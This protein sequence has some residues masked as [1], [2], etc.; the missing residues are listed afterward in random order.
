[1]RRSPGCLARLFEGE[2]VTILASKRLESEHQGRVDCV[3]VDSLVRTLYEQ[4]NNP[5][6]S[7]ECEPAGSCKRGV[8]E[9]RD[10][11]IRHAGGARRLALVAIGSQVVGDVLALSDHRHDSL[12]DGFGRVQLTQMP[13]HHRTAQ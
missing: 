13:E 8:L 2:V 9:T 3:P 12:L 4:R 7:Q 6:G 5:A 11:G 1:M 10:D